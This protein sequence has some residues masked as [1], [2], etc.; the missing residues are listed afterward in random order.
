MLF[1]Q[2]Y[3]LL[4]LLLGIIFTSDLATG[5]FLPFGVEPSAGCESCKSSLSFSNPKSNDFLVGNEIP[6]LPFKT[7]T[8]WSGNIPIP[9]TDSVKN[10]TLSFWLWGKDDHEP[11]KDLVIWM[12]GGPGCSSLLASSIENGPFLF[13]SANGTLSTNK[14]SWTLAAN[15]FYLTQPVG[16]TF[17]TFSSSNITNEDQVSQHLVLFLKQ[18]FNIFEELRSTNIWLIGESYDGQM[19]PFAFNAI[20]RNP[21][22]GKAS[23]LKGGMLIS[24]FFSDLTAQLATAAYPFAVEHQRQL[25][26]SDKQLASLKNQSDTCQLTDFISKYMS[27]PPKGRLPNP[28]TNCQVFETYTETYTDNDPNYNIYNVNK[29]KDLGYNSV[30]QAFFNRTDVQDY[31]RAPHQDFKL[32]RSVFQQNNLSI[33]GDL[34]GPSDRT[35]S[36]EHSLFAQMVEGSKRFIVMSGALDGLIFAS[37]VQLVLQNLTWNG[38][39]GF[40]A[41]LHVPLYDL[42]GKQRA[43][44]TK[45]E[46]HLRYVLVPDAGHILPADQPSFALNALFAL[47]GRPYWK[48]EKCWSQED[49]HHG[50]TI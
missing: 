48:K 14:Y 7:K 8:S 32:C 2:A 47:L 37:G 6:G 46:R 44:A 21:P 33:S 13:D 42:E 11:G 19:M 31:I 24:P 5:S 34:S 12:S 27:F 1:E 49:L 30:V 16:A 25:N 20:K 29:P 9:D 17:T 36:F 4:L 26:F 23:S 15:M 39:Q 41:P 35:P 18:F 45:S 38:E 28:S 22:T 50:K 10:G 40:N 3:A 43:I